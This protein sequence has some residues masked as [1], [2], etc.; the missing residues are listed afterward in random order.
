MTLNSIK[1]I[2]VIFLLLISIVSC[3]KEEYS[4]GNLKSPSAMNLTAT[5]A[6]VDAGNPNGNGTGT[7][8]IS[9]SGQDAI[10]Y[11]MDFGDGKVQM[12]PSGS[13]TYKYAT[14]GTNEYTITV[15]A[16]GT[17]G[18]TSVISKKVKVFV[19]FN[20]P[21]AILEHL[22]GESG[23]VWICDK[24]A[25]GHFGVGPADGVAPIWYAASANSRAAD[26]FYNDEITFRKTSTNQITMNVD[27]KGETFVLGAALSYY[28]LGGPEGA[29][30]IVTS[31]I[32][33][34]AF[35]NATSGIDAANSTQIQFSVPGNGLVMIGLGSNSY[36]ILSLTATKMHLRTIGA[37]GLAWYQKLT[38]KP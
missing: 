1:N 5:V 24:D 11:K 18:I 14:P 32:K 30:P 7:V 9:V 26:G 15:T 2:T 3:Q 33:N 23:K 31:G 25:D 19:A 35:M 12:V 13:I 37:D 4:F 16:V 22:A 20:I 6:G 29:Y 28:S 27:N 17:G 34:L 36:E 21:A 10:T 38:L 8:N